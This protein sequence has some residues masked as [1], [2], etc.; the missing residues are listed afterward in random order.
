MQKQTEILVLLCCPVS[1]SWLQNMV[2]DPT[3]IAKTFEL[4]TLPRSMVRKNARR[5]GLGWAALHQLGWAGLPWAW[6]PCIDWAVCMLGWAA[7]GS[8]L[9][10]G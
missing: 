5:A 1:E 2:L 3:G 6:L 10:Q 9:D 4:H 7:L 8:G